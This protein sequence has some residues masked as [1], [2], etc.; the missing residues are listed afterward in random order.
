MP[1]TTREAKKGTPN[2]ADTHRMYKRLRE[3]VRNC[4]PVAKRVLASLWH[5]LYWI[6]YRLYS[7]IARHRSAIALAVLALLIAASGFFAR[8]LQRVLNTSVLTAEHIADLRAVLMQVGGA[9]IGGTTIAFSLVLFAMQVN[10]ERMPHGLFRKLSSDPRLLGAFV[11]TF[12][13]AILI[14]ASALVPTTK[15]P[16]AATLA[17]LSAAW[18]V[19]IIPLIFLY[20]YR[21]A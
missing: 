21:R 11:T 10:I 3:I 8:D 7:W 12:L 5:R 15:S 4:Q 9:L 16:Y 2:I 20:A 14:A 19:A 13:L 18:A 1:I 6:R 17:V